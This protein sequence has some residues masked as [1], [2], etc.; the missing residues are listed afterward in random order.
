MNALG[1]L[2]EC[3]RLQ[4]LGS[5]SSN[6]QFGMFNLALIRACA[7]GSENCGALNYGDL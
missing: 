5:M 3:N 4:Y 7:V 6:V 2:V 1:F